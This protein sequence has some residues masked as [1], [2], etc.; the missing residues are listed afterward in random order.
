MAQNGNALR[1]A[2]PLPLTLVDQGD[3]M[4]DTEETY[5]V[6]GEAGED[7]AFE[8]CEDMEIA[9][10]VKEAM[11]ED[12]FQVRLYQANEIE[13]VEEDEPSPGSGKRTA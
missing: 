3:E 5:I 9:I 1:K 8:I 13:I 12:G 2:P 11:E 7:V 10:G 4:A 6:V